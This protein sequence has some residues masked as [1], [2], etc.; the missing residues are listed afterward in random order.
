MP[1]NH[2]KHRL[3]IV[4][5]V[6]IAAGLCNP[7]AFAR[8]PVPADSAA[9]SRTDSGPCFFLRNWKGG[10]K[11][12]PNA[13]VIYIRVDH[14]VYRL[15][16]QSSYSLLRDPWAVLINKTTMSMVCSPLDFNLTVSNQAG[17]QQW[18]IV[19]SMTRLT[20]A[21]AAALPKA[22]RP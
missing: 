18:P 6:L 11:A 13:R 17:I 21:Q 5:G 4:A 9:A 7:A 14:S 8:V 12:A 2:R 20:P 3:R 15:D 22:L 19:R 16:L 1:E 10:W